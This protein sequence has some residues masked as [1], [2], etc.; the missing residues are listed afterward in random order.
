MTQSYK[1]YKMKRKERP[2]VE[3]KNFDFILVRNQIERNHLI[4]P[5]INLVPLG[6]G[7]SDRV[8]RSII[9]KSCSVR[10]VLFS[11]IERPYYMRVSLVLDKQVVTV[12]STD[13][14]NDTRVITYDLRD[15]LQFPSATNFIDN[16]YYYRNL[17]NSKRFKTLASEEYKLIPR[18]MNNRSSGHISFHLD[19]DIPIDFSPTNLDNVPEAASI[20]EGPQG[21]G[22]NLTRPSGLTSYN[23]K[24]YMTDFDQQRLYT[25]DPDTGLATIVGMAPHFGLIPSEGNLPFPS[26]L[27]S[28]NGTLYMLEYRHADLTVL[29]PDTGIATYP[30]QPPPSH[31]AV[32]ENSPSGLT[33]HRGRLYMVGEAT[34]RLYTVNTRTGRATSLGVLTFPGPLA[35]NTYSP[36]GLAS[37][38]GV[39]YMIASS[40]TGA[41]N[42]NS[43]LYTIEPS[44]R[45]VTRFNA[46][47]NFGVNE[48]RPQGLASHGGKLYMVG[49]DT[50][51]LHYIATTEANVPF[52]GRPVSNNLFVVFQM[53]HTLVSHTN[54]V[55]AVLSTRI[56][57]IDGGSSYLYPSK[58]KKRLIKV[59]VHE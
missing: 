9:V 15:Y 14:A 28:H 11:D 38:R 27:A 6:P 42:F 35:Q 17:S 8:S 34:R 45:V 37:H 12:P 10:Y 18:G 36:Q 43:Y 53:M 41:T 40:P 19:T 22:L 51:R 26:A 23:G 24:L 57:F 39:L 1:H 21:F 32:G 30:R 59:V 3:L 46:Q 54:R 7:P 56:R 47:P 13:L 16:F 31:F 4:Y 25:I 33:S 49:R 5:S 29:D 58:K 44:T 48:R 50:R 55:I 20:F 52:E 2:N